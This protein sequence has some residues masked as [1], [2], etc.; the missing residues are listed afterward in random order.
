MPI[1]DPQMLIAI[2]AVINSLAAL[3][4]AVRTVFTATRAAGCPPD[5]P[6]DFAAQQ[7]KHGRREQRLEVGPR[8]PASVLQR[9]RLRS[10]TPSTLA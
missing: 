6:L 10:A 8:L 7:S 2:A 1:P 4:S 3:I 9:R 5:N